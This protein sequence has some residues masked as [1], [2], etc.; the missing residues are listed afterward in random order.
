MI[1][2]NINGKIKHVPNHQPDDISRLMAIYGHTLTLSYKKQEL[3]SNCVFQQVHFGM[4]ATERHM[5]IEQK[6]RT[7]AAAWGFD[8][9]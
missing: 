5:K 8:M 2:P 1:I 4:G 3:N 9:V 6:R 7:I